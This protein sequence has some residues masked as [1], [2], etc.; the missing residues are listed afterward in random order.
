MASMI[1]EP[2]IS[3]PKMVAISIWFTE[4]MLAHFTFASEEHHDGR[5]F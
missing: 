4:H 3:K 5:I 2:N 1:I